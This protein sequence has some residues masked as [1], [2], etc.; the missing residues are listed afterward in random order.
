ML[1]PVHYY[2]AALYSLLIVPCPIVWFCIKQMSTHQAWHVTSKEA[3]HRFSLLFFKGVPRPA[4]LHSRAGAGLTALSPRGCCRC[5]GPLHLFRS[6]F[7]GGGPRLLLAAPTSPAL[8][9][10]EE[11]SCLCSVL[12]CSVTAGLKCLDQVRSEQIQGVAGVL[13]AR[14]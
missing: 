14:T 13:C 2:A 8:L 11:P 7:P 10:Y 3:Q 9:L 1:P 4:S 5:R 12:H 6:A